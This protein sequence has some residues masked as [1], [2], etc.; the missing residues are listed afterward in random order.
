MAK[1]SISCSSS[2]TLT[3]SQIKEKLLHPST[4]SS[5]LLESFT[6]LSTTDTPAT[7]QSAVRGWWHY[8][9]PDTVECTCLAGP[10]KAQELHLRYWYLRMENDSQKPGDTVHWAFLHDLTLRLW[11]IT[12]TRERNTGVTLPLPALPKSQAPGTVTWMLWCPE[13]KLVLSTW[14]LPIGLI[15]T[16]VSPSARGMLSLEIPGSRPPDN[17]LFK[18]G[19]LWDF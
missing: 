13:R 1:C 19:L 10:H 8:L 15:S 17:A 18:F 4:G 5:V 6:C 3:L 7:K 16:C 12:E 2:I 11:L 9:Q 14:L